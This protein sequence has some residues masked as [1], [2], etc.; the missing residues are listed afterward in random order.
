M[1]YKNH[2]LSLIVPIYNDSSC[3]SPFLQRVLP[4]LET[5]RNRFSYDFEIIFVMDPSEDDTEKIILEARHKNHAIKIIKLSRRFGQQPA[6]LAGIFN[7][8]GEACIVLDVDLQDPPELMI[9]MMEKHLTGPY[10]VVYA[11]RTKRLGEPWT[12]RFLT[13]IGYSVMNK[14]SSIE[15]PKNAGD[16]RLIDRRVI[17]ELHK[18]NERHGFFRGLVPFVGFRQTAVYF[19]RQP[20]STGATKYNYYIGSITNGMNALVCFSNKLL[21][22]AAITGLVLFFLSI[23][24]S[25]VVVYLKFVV[26]LPFASGIATVMIL[27]VFASGLQSFFVGILGMYIGR[28]YDETKQRPLYIIDKKEGF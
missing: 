21:M 4:I 12:K 22:L 3:V 1:A 28:I 27:I 20:R 13:S 14:L 24:L 11:V 7:C 10:N 8:Q 23:V 19:E 17:E 18:L 16:F 26:R 25:L 6:I 9:E 2:L 15:I 5:I